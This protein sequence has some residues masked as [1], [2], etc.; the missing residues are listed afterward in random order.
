[1]AVL[2]DSVK[3]ADLIADERACVRSAPSLRRGAQR[4]PRTR[5]AGRENR[6]PGCPGHKLADIADKLSLSIKAV[7]THKSNVLDTM[8]PNGR[9][10]LVRHATEHSLLAAVR[11]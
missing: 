11:G 9:F 2:E 6:D 4:A 5:C 8:T 10:D 1:M 3:R 7:S